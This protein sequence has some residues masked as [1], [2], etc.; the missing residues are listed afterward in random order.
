MKAAGRVL[1]LR[2][3]ACDFKQP[4]HDRFVA[5][6]CGQRDH[7]AHQETGGRKM[8]GCAMN[9]TL[10]CRKKPGL[11]CIDLYMIWS[12]ASGW[13]M[14]RMTDPSSQQSAFSTPWNTSALH[15]PAEC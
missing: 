13:W 8:R 11:R 12:A 4:I 2:T 14:G 9:G 3:T 1:F 15:V 6:C 10:R 7:G 5:K